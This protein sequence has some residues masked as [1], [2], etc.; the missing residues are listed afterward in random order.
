MEVGLL[1]M[2]FILIQHVDETSLSECWPLLLSLL[3]D[4]LQINL[5]PPAI[6]LLLTCVNFISSVFCSPVNFYHVT[7]FTRCAYI[8]LCV[9]DLFAYLSNAVICNDI[10]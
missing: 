7:G 6:F 3:K 10:E 1:R 9:L 4:A 5:T 2:F 8:S